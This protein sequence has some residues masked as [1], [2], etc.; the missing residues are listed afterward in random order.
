M[1]SP[2]NACN[3]HWQVALPCEYLKVLQNPCTCV[4][5]S[6]SLV[7]A[8]NTLGSL[9][10]SKCIWWSFPLYFFLPILNWIGRI[11]NIYTAHCDMLKCTKLLEVVSNRWWRKT[12]LWV[13][14]FVHLSLSYC[15]KFWLFVVSFK[16]FITNFLLDVMTSQNIQ[17][18][19]KHF[20]LWINNWR[21]HRQE[22]YTYMQPVNSWCASDIHEIWTS[23][24]SEDVSVGPL[25]CN[26]MWTS[27]PKKKAVCSSRTLVLHT[28]H[29]AL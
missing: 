5:C 21:F 26:A 23:C 25:G 4:N 16:Q 17:Q 12:N 7:L 19:R 15:L 6:L 13:L 27:G 29:M 9:L 20:F 22:T 24:S 8:L 2:V 14:I 3:Q 18:N 28:S 11:N 10:Y 1:F